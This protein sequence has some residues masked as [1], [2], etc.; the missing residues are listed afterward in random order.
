M[1]WL[2]SEN[3]DHII[4]QLYRDCWLSVFRNISGT[5]AEIIKKHF[6]KLYEGESVDIFMQ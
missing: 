5:V 6:Q 1:F 3:S 2:S 4:T